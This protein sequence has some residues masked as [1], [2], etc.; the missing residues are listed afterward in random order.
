M[1]RHYVLLEQDA[2]FVCFV[3]ACCSYDIYAP[4]I[5]VAFHMYAIKEN[6][7]KRKK[8]KLFWEN[9]ALF[10]GSGLMAMKRLN[11]IIGMGDPGDDYYRKDEE[12]YGLGSVRTKE[13]F[14]SLY[15]IH[16]ETQTVE[17]H[18]CTFVG[19]PMMKKFKPFLRQN[20][21]GIDFSKINFAWRD[22]ALQGN[23]Q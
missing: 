15:G 1:F 5:S 19:K 14:F 16:P 4:E 7:E 8:V 20:G 3:D 22:P 17:D 21:M 9:G 12:E 13:K 10:P 11:G 23:Q 2:H 6:A 18:L